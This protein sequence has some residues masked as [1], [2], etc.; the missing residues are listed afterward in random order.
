MRESTGQFMVLIQIHGSWVSLLRN[1]GGA[2][3]EYATG[4]HSHV[5]RNAA[6]QSPNDQVVWYQVGGTP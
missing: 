1:A 5:F 4:T 3:L 2:Y 6:F